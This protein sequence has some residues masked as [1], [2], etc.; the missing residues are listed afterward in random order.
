MKKLYFFL[1]LITTFYSKNLLAQCSNG[2]YYDQIFSVSTHTGVPYGENIEYNG[3]DTILLMDIFEPS[4]DNFARRP[5]II[6]AF[7]GGFNSGLRQSPDLEILCNYFAQRGYVTCTIDYRIGFENG[8]K[9]DTNI[10][11]ALIRASQDM[12]AATR[13]FYKDANT[14]NTYRIDTNQIFV[15]GVSA[16]A[17]AALN[18]AYGKLTSF[19]RPVPGFALPSLAELGGVEGNSGNPGYSSKVKGVISLCGAI[20]DTIWITANDPILYAEHGTADH[21]VP[22]YYDSIANITNVDASFFGGGDI[23]NR[24]Q[25]VGLNSFTYLFQGAD[26]CPFVIPYPP[27]YLN[28]IPYMDT[29]ERFVRDFLSVNTVCDETAFS[30]NNIG[31]ENAISVFPN[32]SSTY[33]RVVSNYT[34]T[35]QLELYSVDGKMLESRILVPGASAYLNKDKYGAGLYLLKFNS[36]T[37]GKAVRTEKLVWY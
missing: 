29:T 14:T 25:N 22:A 4:G 28:T 21:V 15:G 34:E 10:F 37:G 19:S 9:S 5:L 20:A 7:G 33:T 31:D 24:V 32:P 16:G 1:V 6:W 27:T 26:H 18:M 2:R 23:R 13:F 3:Q 11:R 17:F 30:I 8:V 12:K 35:L 36:A